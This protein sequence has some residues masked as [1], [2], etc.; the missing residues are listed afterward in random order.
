M[1]LFR[2][3]NT[4]LRSFV[5]ELPP[6]DLVPLG[7]AIFTLF[8]VLG[9]ITDILNGARQNVWLLVAVTVFSGLLALGYGFGS[10]RRNRWLLGATIVAQFLWIWTAHTLFARVPL[11]PPDRAAARIG[12]DAGIVILLVTISYSSFLWFINVAAARYLRVR[13]EIELAHQIHEVLVPKIATTIGAFEFAGFS[14]PSGEVGGDLV[15]VVTAPAADGGA[16]NWV[17]YVADVSGHG[18]SSGVVMG[19]FKSALRMRLRQGGSLAS[20]LDDL[21]A[22]LFPLK[23]ASMFVTAACVRTTD[24]GGVEYAVAGH[25]PILRLRAGRGETEEITT[26]QIPIGMFEDYRFSAAS[27]DCAPGDLLVLITDGLTEVFDGHDREF[28]IDRAKALLASHANRPL[29]DVANALVAA[30][31][32]HG[33]QLDDQTLLLIRR[34]V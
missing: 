8:A 10:M 4:S 18:V 31:R 14:K 19:M 33:P 6:G 28:G 1:R 7:A 21:N 16:P 22:V 20:V 13:A 3:F 5:G 27:I 34:R 29:A 32:A 11:N 25:L 17:G 12:L 23:S 30:A 2:R 9:P 15:D 26:P 24:A